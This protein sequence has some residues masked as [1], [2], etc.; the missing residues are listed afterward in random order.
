[1]K[2]SI[3]EKIIKKK[4]Q[5]LMLSQA[6]LNGWPTHEP[7]LQAENLENL[8]GHGVLGGLVVAPSL[9][10]LSPVASE[11]RDCD[12]RARESLPELP[13][14]RRRGWR[15]SGNACV[16]DDGGD[17]GVGG[18]QLLGFLDGRREKQHHLVVE[19]PTPPVILALLVL[20][21][22][23]FLVHL[24]SSPQRAFDL[25]QSGRGAKISYKVIITYPRCQGQQKARTFRAFSRISYWIKKFSFPRIKIWFAPM[26]FSGLF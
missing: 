14:E 21:N 16:H 11:A 9:N 13:H 25:F 1:M 10:E 3:L 24:L 8:R 7:R 17:V 26:F 15:T 18:E 23:H 2:I 22:E 6:G 20:N 19:L 4:C 12:H 5:P